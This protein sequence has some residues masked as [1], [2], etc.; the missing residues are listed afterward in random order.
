MADETL[1]C[2]GIDYVQYI[3]HI[4]IYAHEKMQTETVTIHLMQTIKMKKKIVLSS[5]ELA[6]LSS[7]IQL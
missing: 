3:W 1:L 4:S 7:N 5:Y 2:T 6:L